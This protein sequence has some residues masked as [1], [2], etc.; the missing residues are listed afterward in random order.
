MLKK[1]FT[2][3]QLIIALVIIGVLATLGLPAYQKAIEDSKSKVCQTNLEALSKALDIYAMDNDT[4]PG[5]LSE[6]P[7]EYIQKAYAQVL[8]KKGAW[9][10]RLAYFIL[11]WEKKGLAYAQAPGLMTLISKGDVRLITCPADPTPPAQGGISYGL[12]SALINMTSQA[13]R[14]LPANTVLIGDCENNGFN[15]ISQ[16]SENHKLHGENYA[17]AIQGDEEVWEIKG[18]EP[19]HRREKGGHGHGEGH[20]HVD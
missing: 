20:V 18:G 3:I 11:D 7:P 19:K 13:Y 2:L 10:I 14:A 1:A 17:I 12:N 4:M 9:K 6:L 16:L 15:N 5:S 8:Q